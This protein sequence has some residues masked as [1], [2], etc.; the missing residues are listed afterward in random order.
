MASVFKK[1]RD[2]A[3]KLASWYIAYQDEDGRRRTVKGCPDKAA[4]EAMARKLE[5]DADLR[6]RGVVDPKAEAYAA[7]EAKPLADHLDAW[8]ESLK[9]E[10]AT[11]KYVELVLGRA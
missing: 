11:P 2:K 3:N 1:T 8:G 5:S 6:R 4:T 9:A 10:G 7:H